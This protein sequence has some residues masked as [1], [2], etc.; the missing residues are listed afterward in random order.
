M[1]DLIEFINGFPQG[2]S[3]GDIARY[4]KISRTTLNR[5]LKGEVAR[6]T[7][8]VSGKGPA[9]RYL[10]ADPLSALRLYFEKPHTERVVASYR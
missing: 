6:G 5:R 2:V 7:I 4:F 1:N 10:S 3:A 8:V 9:T